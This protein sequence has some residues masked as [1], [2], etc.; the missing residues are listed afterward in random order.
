M[1]DLTQSHEAMPVERRRMEQ[2]LRESEARLRTVVNSAAMILYAFDR[3]G[4]FTFSEGRGLQALGLGAGE[5]VGRSVF[6]VY[7]HSPKVIEDCRRA[8]QGEEFTSIREVGGLTFEARY[9]AL[10]KADETLAGVIGVAT[11]IT[12]RVRAEAALRASEASYRA[13]FELASDAIYVHDLETGA[14]LDANNQACELHG[15]SLEELRERGV[16]GF[17]DERP[18][19]TWQEAWE[20]FERA[21]AGEP[22][23]FE[24]HFRSAGGEA[25]WTEVGLR[26]ATILGE[27]RVLATAR[28]ITDRKQ[29]EAAREQAYA[30]LEERVR[31]R[32]AALAAINAALEAEI[33]ERQ[34]VAE[35]LRASEEHFRLLIENSSDVAT[36]LDSEG[37][38]RYQSPS[39]ERVLGYRP[40]E[41]VGSSAFSRIHPEDSGAARETLGKIF[42]NPGRTF[43]VEFRYKHSN[44][45]WTALEA[46]GR[47]LLPDSAAAGVIINSR[48]ITERRTAAEA[49]RA[50]KDEAERANRA[51]SEFLSRMSHELRTPMNSILG[52]AQ[53]LTRRELP[54]DQRRAVDHIL[55]AGRHLLN[56]INEVLDIARIES[57]RQ[58]LSLE[59]VQVRLVL[60]ESLNLIRPLAEQRD[61][62]IHDEVTGCADFV[63]ADRQRLTQVLLNL[64]SNAVKYNRPGGSVRL[65]C[66]RLTDESGGRLRVLVHDTGRG[67]PADRMDELFVPFSRL[68]A[69]QSDEEGTGLGL[70]LS[71][72][73]MEAMGGRLLAESTPGVGSVFIVELAEAQSPL[74]QL[75]LEASSRPA[76]V[77]E[78]EGA[79]ATILYVED[80]LANLTLVETIFAGRPE[81]TLVP[82][83]QGTLGLDLAFEHAP[84]LVLLDLHLPDMS[85]D[86]VLRRLRADPRTRE[87]PVIVISADALPARI[88]QLREQGAHGYLTKPLDLDEFLGAVDQVL[89]SRRP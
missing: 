41:L 50:A 73:L 87:T 49:L 88:E 9:S 13:I 7:E 40:E 56:L 48:D 44:G 1:P 55:K 60:Q 29:A 33:A 67:I 42:A 45:M 12:E 86:E 89:S 10:Y 14:I 58:P 70:A 22:Q 65:T 16:K 62:I 82:A 6:E 61:C 26:R 75:T 27:E 37:I 24:W 53:L 74:A 79:A 35:A 77:R 64:L 31:E 36:I 69:E 47:T 15:V 63:H 28:N 72:R 52:F 46:S 57:D 66:E 8:L 39:I 20:H 30:E 54:A 59:P 71:Q 84:D 11:D 85:G 76:R 51:K 43:T 23:R 5:V 3:D 25:V 18:P 21:A 38:N 17:S 68:G 2:A 4:V 19:Y 32:T 80:N 83:L 81:I 78:A 34:R